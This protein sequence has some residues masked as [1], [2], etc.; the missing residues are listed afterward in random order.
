MVCEIRK[1]VVVGAGLMGCGIAQVCVQANFETV[2][3]DFTEEIL[4]KA[5]QR[6]SHSLRQIH[7]HKTRQEQEEIIAKVQARLTTSTQLEASLTNASLVIEAIVEDLEPK[8]QLLARV[9][10]S[11]PQNMLIATNTSSLKLSDIGRNLK[12]K[13]NFGGLHFFNPVPKMKLLEVI[14]TDQTS[15]QTLQKLLR[16]GKSIGKTTVVCK[17]T[18]GFIAN[19]ILIPLMNEGLGIVDRAEATPQDVDLACKIGLGFPL[20]PFEL[21]DF[22]GL[23]TAHNIRQGWIKHY[24][25]E[26]TV[27]ASAILEKGSYGLVVLRLANNL[28]AS[29]LLSL[30]LHRRP[31][32]TDIQC[33]DNEDS[34]AVV[35]YTLTSSGRYVVNVLNDGNH[36]KDSVFIV[37]MEDEDDSNREDAI[38]I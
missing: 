12:R 31:L 2:L 24:P 10:A 27:K 37:M 21:L 9:E 4:S 6:I 3:V 8:Q 35:E 5:R 36:I 16:F 1:L 32:K 26:V 34:T 7:K 11:A 25:E 17:D 20:G 14:T 15:N 19:R 33:V 38:S 22:V 28:L 30:I 29:S 23:D 18:P 13:H